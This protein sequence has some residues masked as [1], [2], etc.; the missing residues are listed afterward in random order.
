MRPSPYQG[1]PGRHMPRAP[2]ALDRDEHTM[3]KEAAGRA[4]KQDGIDRREASTPQLSGFLAPRH[5]R[6][7][8]F[9]GWLKL[10]SRLPFRWAIVLHKT[11]GR[12][13][14][15]RG[16][17]RAR[18]VRRNLEVCFPELDAA[19]I[20]ALVVRQFEAIGA[21]VAETAMA[22]C[23][24]PE[25]LRGRFRIV[26]LEHFQAALSRGR[27]VILFTGHMTSLE[28]CGRAFRDFT[29]LFAC[30]FTA[31]RD[32]LMNEIQRRG[33]LRIADESF[34]SS[35]VRA[36]LRSLSRNAA[37]WYAPD[38][39]Y[40]GSNSRLVDFFGEPAMTNVA[41]SKLAAISGA[42]VIPYFCRRL[43]NDTEYELVFR[44]EL[45]DFPTD[46]A[47]A[48]TQRLMKEL[49]DFIR[50]S[51]DQYLWLHKKFKGRPAGYPDIYA[52]RSTRDMGAEG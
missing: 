5:W 35:D 20:E 22:W 41:T 47:A 23:A 36:M 11:A 24:S 39:V 32:A 34:L 25:K 16:S 8:L 9:W 10:T 1:R 6:Y 31:R 18:T 46:D 4:R 15:R 29:P 38:R 7:W 43:S 28:L 49:E 44:P 3:R 52:S 33:R 42:T 50:L 48:D 26:G 27:G 21:L 14:Y 45:A 17:R 13:T 2:R 19:E 40:L 30:M 51:P 37:V 12:L